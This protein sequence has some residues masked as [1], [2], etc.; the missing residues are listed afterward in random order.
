MLM[1]TWQIARR[2]W[3]VVFVGL[4]VTVVLVVLAVSL[5]PARYVATTQLVML[6]PHSAGQGARS[7]GAITSWEQ[8]NPYLGMA[9]LEGMADLVSRAMMDEVTAQALAKAGVTGTYT[10]QRDTM[11][12]APILVV[13]VEDVVLSGASA[14][15]KV[16]TEQVPLAASRLQSDSLVPNAARITLAEVAR[17]G[18]PAW[19]GKGQIRA[20]GVAGVAGLVLTLLAASL[21]DAWSVRRRRAPVT[22][23]ARRA[24]DVGTSSLGAAVPATEDGSAADAVASS[25]VTTAD[26]A[27][28]TRYL[29]VEDADTTT[30]SQA[31][32][33]HGS[34]DGGPDIGPAEQGSRSSAA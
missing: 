10:V 8:E 2:R 13:S 14:Q 7:A 9:G 22:A 25:D 11:A 19:S 12:A 1:T 4:L 28:K 18:T 20:A 17:P 31:P 27:G 5:V 16:V 26:S 6:P 30:K 29:Q 3:Y 21:M 34:E 33:A 15:L 32:H 23:D 24:V